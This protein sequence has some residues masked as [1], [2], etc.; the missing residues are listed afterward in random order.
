M[1]GLRQTLL[2]LASQG[3]EVIMK[4]LILAGGR[5]KRLNELSEQQNKCMININGKPTIEYSLQCA[6]NTKISEIVIVVGYKAEEIINT[7]GNKYGDKI[8]KYVIQPEPKGL[9]HAIECAKNTIGKEDFMLML[10]DEFMVGP[11]H[12]E[13]I[14]IF[15]KENLFGVCGVVKV[16]D[17]SL[18]NKTYS[19]IESND[20]QIYR[21]IEKP[22][23]PM[24]NS[25]GTGNCIF[26]NEILSY[27]GQTPINQKRGEKEL[28]DLIQCAIDDGNIVKSFVIC[29]KYFNIN[30]NEELQE[31]NSCFAHL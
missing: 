29:N 2:F 6:V 25:M 17:V 16:E 19:I 3:N 11:R 5:G 10:G 26:R 30:S 28:P 22:S 27:I 4:A 8:I 1:T 13:M 31:A 20:N 15:K 14:S 9:V 12:Q 18:I 21:L 24:N 23:K 7:Y